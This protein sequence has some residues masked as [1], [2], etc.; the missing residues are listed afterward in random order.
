V[1]IYEHLLLL[2]IVMVGT[3]TLEIVEKY[4]KEK[5]YWVEKE[6]GKLLVT[7]RFAT[8]QQQCEVFKTAVG[9]EQRPIIRVQSRVGKYRNIKPE[10]LKEIL[11]DVNQY[12][13]ARPEYDEASQDLMI[14]GCSLEEALSEAEIVFIVT[15][16]A[17]VADVFEK[18]Y[19]KGKDTN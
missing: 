16:V 14:A 6:Q 7:V 5:N 19:F 12:V 11:T 13:Y 1:F 8:R 18:K 10:K 3:N 4:F 17:Y 15:E 9:T 2:L